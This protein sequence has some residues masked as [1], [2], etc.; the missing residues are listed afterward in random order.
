LNSVSADDKARIGLLLSRRMRDIGELVSHPNVVEVLDAL[1]NRTMTLADL[2]STTRAGRRAVTAALRRVA[3]HGLVTTTDGGSWD[4]LPPHCTACQLTN[5]GH[6]LVETLFTP[7][8]LD[9]NARGRRSRSPHISAGGSVL[10]RIGR[11]IV[12]Q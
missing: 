11:G 12:I 7:I 1:S 6:G 9:R 10:L 3:A 2:T 5:R 8:G 4:G